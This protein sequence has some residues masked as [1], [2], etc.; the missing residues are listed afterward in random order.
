MKT[1]PLYKSSSVSWHGSFPGHWKLIRGKNLYRKESRPVLD[2]YE[3]I[4]CF[5]DGIVTLRKNRRVTGFTESLKEIGYQGI[6]KGDLVIHVMDA[7]AGSIGVSD[8]EGK[9]T[10]VYSVCT[11]KIDLN[12]YYYAYLLRDIA[13]KGYIQSLYKGIRERSSDFR[14]DVFGNQ[15]YPVPP[16]E[17]Q[18]Q[19][20]RFLNWKVSEINRLI[21]IKMKE[22]V[23]LE[24]L[25]KA[26]VSHVVTHGL[27][28]SVPTQYSGVYWLG[29]IPLHWDIVKLRHILNPVSI[30]KRSDLPL[31]SVVREQGVIIRDVDDKET[32]HNYIPD[33][34]SN[35]KLVCKNQFA[36]NKM[37]A[38]QGSYGISPYTGI[39]SPAYFVFNVDFENLDYFHYAIRSK[40]YVNFFAQSSDGIR[41]GQWDLQMDRMKEIPFFVPPAEEQKAIVDYIKATIPKYQETIN[42]IS[43]QIQRLHEFKTRLISDTVTGKIDVRGIEIPKYTYTAEESIDDD[44]ESITEGQEG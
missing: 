6:K 15:F 12:N 31:L 21:N 16:R 35:Y 7:F 30:K 2:N 14:F 43:E 25:K 19:I 5:R 8:S 44:S 17:E 41:V 23:R 29:E 22:I 26:V 10:P 27:D 40:V 11:A 24:E 38:W 1:Y 32:N 4:T 9:G 13:R 18:D 20:V 37:K 28:S 39:V 42:K 34:L 33:D 36:M 3:I